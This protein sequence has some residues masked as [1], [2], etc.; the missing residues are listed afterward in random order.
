MSY[1]IE[2]TDTTTGERR[3]YSSDWDWDGETDEY[4]WAEGNFACDCNR[5]LF[6]ARAVGTPEAVI[7][8]APCGLTRFTVAIAVDGEV[9]YDE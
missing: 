6:F 7:D 8:E 3:A 2:I 1:T 4:I 5:S 9:V